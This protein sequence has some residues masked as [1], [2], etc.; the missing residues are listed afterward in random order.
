MTHFSRIKNN[1]LNFFN[2]KLWQKKKE[3]NEKGGYE[4]FL[5]PLFFF[6]LFYLRVWWYNWCLRSPKSLATAT[7][8]HM[9]Y[10]WPWVWFRAQSSTSFYITIP[11]VFIVYTLCVEMLILTTAQY[12]PFKQQSCAIFFNQIVSNIDL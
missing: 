3:M 2:I 4:Y 8:M 1:N 11:F 12:I 10:S 6:F 9:H 7:I 5:K